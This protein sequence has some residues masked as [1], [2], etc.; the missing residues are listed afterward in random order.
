MKKIL[1]EVLVCILLIISVVPSVNASEFWTEKQK[2]LPPV[3]TLGF[4][5]SISLFGDTAVIGSQSE[6][7]NKGAAYVFIRTE[8]AWIQ[9]AKLRASNGISGDFFGNSVSI[10]GDTALIGA[11]GDAN[12][13]V[14][15]GAVYVFT[16]NG[17]N[18]IQKTKLVASDGATQDGFGYSVSLSGDTAL[19]GAWHD[20]D[21]ASD[22]GSAYVFTKID[23]NWT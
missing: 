10:Y 7:N 9:Q 14:N 3:P 6:D 22:S 5:C 1:F 13:G 12:R 16:R 15:T 11:R 19:I 21:K 18:W 8:T 23:E 2:L 4:G 20:D 17:N